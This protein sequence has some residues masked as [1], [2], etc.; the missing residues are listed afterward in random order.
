VDKDLGSKIEAGVQAKAA[1]QDP[2][3]AGQANPARGSMQAKA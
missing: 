3:A 2:K 1:E